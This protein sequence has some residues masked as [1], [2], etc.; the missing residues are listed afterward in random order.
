VRH[1]R[2]HLHPAQH[3]V[4]ADGRHRVGLMLNGIIGQALL[5]GL[6]VALAARRFLCVAREEIRARADAR[7]R[8][9]A[10]VRGPLTC[11]QWLTQANGFSATEGA[12]NLYTPVRHTSS[13][14]SGPLTTGAPLRLL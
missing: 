2:G 14:D 8:L 11:R 13:V 12:G 6:R 5:A 10:A 9:S 1:L 4:G 7:P 3:E